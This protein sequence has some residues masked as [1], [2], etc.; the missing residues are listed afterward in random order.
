MSAARAARREVVADLSRFLRFRSVSAGPGQAGDLGRCAQWLAGRLRRSGLADTRLVPTGGGPPMVIG[1]SADRP[2]RPHLLVYGHY[3][4][5]P[6]PRD[7]WRTDPFTAVV[8][9][10]NLVGRGAADNKGPIMAHVA[11]LTAVIRS[12]GQ[13]PLNVSCVFDGEEEIGSP[14]LRAALFRH[15]HELA[16]DVAVVSDTRI[17]GPDRPALVYALRGSITFEIEVRGQ[18]RD[19]H[20]GAFGGAVHNPAHALADLLSSFHGPDNRVA[21]AGF[22]DGVRVPVP[23]ER[24]RMRT[25]GPTDAQLRSSAGGR[26]LWGMAGP[27]AYER[28]TLLP[29]LNVISL[30]SGDHRVTA[31]PGRASAIVNVR[32][33]AGQDPAAVVEALRGHIA[34]TLPTTVRATLRVVSSTG[35]AETMPGHPAMRVAAQ[36]Y[37]H[38]FGRSPVLLRSGGT[39]PAVSLMRDIL[40]IPVVLLGF[41]LPD[42]GIHG[43]NEQLNL[44]VF[45]RSVDTCIWFLHG[46]ARPSRA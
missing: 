35:P 16:A 8:S 27:T 37:R 10:G 46:L 5:Q 31:I 40:G 45:W 14:H 34:A 41:T 9:N 26:P 25:H 1:H 24:R 4:V 33:A 43:P 32:V 29:A 15:R 19:V 23:A 6:A 30:R 39:I 21:V 13:L 11:A 7:G 17:L 38:G 44:E 3:D 22:Y 28:T 12:A 20:S 42:A 36:A 2:G 18:P